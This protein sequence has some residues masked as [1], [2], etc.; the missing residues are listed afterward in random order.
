MGHKK[1]LCTITCASQN[2]L[3]NTF[4]DG[5]E[6]KKNIEALTN[7]R[8]SVIG[9]LALP[10]GRAC[11]P[12]LMS[13][14][15]YIDIN[16]LIRL[17]YTLT[18]TKICNCLS[19]RGRTILSTFSQSHAFSDRRFLKKCMLFMVQFHSQYAITCNLLIYGCSIN[20]FFKMNL[21]MPI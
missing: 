16:Y 11:L 4:N 9:L 10:L 14:C 7:L 18:E 5:F 6:R 12:P 17:I 20:I 8:P 15:I 19:V 13:V 1:R 21:N 2:Y 3:T